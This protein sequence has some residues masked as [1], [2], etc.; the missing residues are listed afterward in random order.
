MQNTSP[1]KRDP[2]L[3]WLSRDHHDGLLIGWKIRQGI[4]YKVASARMVDYVMSTFAAE[5]E[6]HF[7]EEEDLIF[8][9]LDRIDALRTR[10]EAEH[11]AIRELIAK[12]HASEVDAATVLLEFADMLQ[13]HIRF[14]ERILFPHVEK[15]IPAQDL[16][17][18]GRQLE[19]DHSNKTGVNW[20]DAFWMKPK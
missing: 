16:D 9:R 5:L 20:P 8:S 15:A 4:A 3:I 6:P 14:E 18:I 10:A 13:A 2:R 1:I 12:L 11:A 19:D 17:A 7:A